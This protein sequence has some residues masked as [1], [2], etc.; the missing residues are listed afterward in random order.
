MKKKILTVLLTLA[1]VFSMATPAF[2]C[3]GSYDYKYEL[4][5]SIVDNC[6]NLIESM[7]AVAQWTPFNDIPAL[8][9]SVNTLVAA[10]EG[11]VKALGFSVVCEY[12]EYVID[13]R[14][15]MIDPL[16]VVPPLDH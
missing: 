14:H 9:L 6:N 11:T 8:L 5:T 2:A 16:R 13:G 1:L 4:A 15:V 7:V 12:T 3:S 10:T